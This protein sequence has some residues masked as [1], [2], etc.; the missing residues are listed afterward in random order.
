MT[1]MYIYIYLSFDSGSAWTGTGP[2]MHD[3]HSRDIA[4]LNNYAQERWEVRHGAD[5]SGLLLHA[6]YLDGGFVFRPSRRQFVLLTFWIVICF[7]H[8]TVL[9]CSCSLFFDVPQYPCYLCFLSYTVLCLVFLLET[10]KSFIWPRCQVLVAVLT[11][12]IA[13]LYLSNSYRQG[14]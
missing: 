10:I 12:R 9:L 13:C 3:K 2:L 5:V 11:R 6:L 8:V 4:F 1:Y 7:Q 14:C